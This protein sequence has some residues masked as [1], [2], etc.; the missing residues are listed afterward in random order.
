MKARSSR[1]NKKIMHA[2]NYD[3]FGCFTLLLSHLP[4]FSVFCRIFVSPKRPRRKKFGNIKM[5]QHNNFYTFF[6]CSS[7]F[8]RS[9]CYILRALKIIYRDFND[10]CRLTNDCGLILIHEN[11]FYNTLIIHSEYRKK[12]KIQQ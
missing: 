4:Q 11:F 7:L 3:A 1:R 8:T 5:Q 2:C 10:Y 12:K 9:F 6:C